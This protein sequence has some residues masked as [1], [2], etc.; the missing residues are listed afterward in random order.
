MKRQQYQSDWSLNFRSYRHFLFSVT[1]TKNL[2][3]FEVNDESN[4]FDWVIFLQSMISATFKKFYEVSRFVKSLVTLILRIPAASQAAEFS[5]TSRWSLEKRWKSAEKFFASKGSKIPLNCAKVKS[6]RNSLL[7]NMSESVEVL[8]ITD[9]SITTEALSELKDIVAAAPPLLETTTKTKRQ[10]ED[11]DDGDGEERAAKKICTEI[12]DDVEGEEEEV[13]VSC[14]W[15]GNERK[16]TDF[17][18]FQ[19][20]ETEIINETE[21]AVDESKI[22]EEVCEEVPDVLE[23]NITDNLAE[24]SIEKSSE[25]IEDEAML[26]E[27]PSRELAEEE[28]EEE[29]RECNLHN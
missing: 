11:D 2:N 27:L 15:W 23:Q 17:L 12:E 24:E 9:T 5:H 21:I 4:F 20:I 6:H 26:E 14:E 3:L 8:E 29:I 19:Q 10:L 18:W 13:T 22:E 28:E 16:I 7:W 25:L 1:E